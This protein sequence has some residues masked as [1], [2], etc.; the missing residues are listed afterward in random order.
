MQVKEDM[1]KMV[2]IPMLRPRMVKPTQQFGVSLTELQERSLVEDGVPLVLRRM[3]EHLRTHGERNPN[4]KENEQMN[5]VLLDGTFRHFFC[6]FCV[7][8]HGRGVYLVF[9]AGLYCSIVRCHFKVP[10]QS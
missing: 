8:P 5:I 4:R 10:V 3:V 6:S 9:Q 1:K 2:Q 7:S